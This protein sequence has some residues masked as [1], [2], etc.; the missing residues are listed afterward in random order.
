LV[1]EAVATE[2]TEIGSLPLFT[3]NVLATA[4]VVARFS[5]YVSVMVVP[6]EVFA[7]EAY[8][9]GVLSTREPF[10]T[11]VV[12]NDAASLPKTS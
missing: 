5:L 10:V 7:I 4:V 2:D 12:D 9:G 11:D 8:T 1:P 3:V 6:V